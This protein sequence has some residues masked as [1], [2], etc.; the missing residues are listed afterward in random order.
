[1]STAVRPARCLFARA[2]AVARSATTPTAA[3]SA[4]STTFLRRQFHASPAHS[5][6]RKPHYPSIKVEDMKRLQEVAG[7]EFPTF[8]EKDKEVLAAKY[9]PEQLAA[10][11]AGEQA[12]DPRDLLVQG[13]KSPNN[14]RDW[15]P[16]ALKYQIDDLRRLQ[17]VLDKPQKAELDPYAD[18]SIRPR[19]EDEM[20]ELLAMFYVQEA[21][22]VEALGIQPGT[23]AE[24]EEEEKS[25]VRY[26]QFLDN[27]RTFMHAN[28]EEGY[29]AL[30]DDSYTVLA[31]ELPKIDELAPRAGS[32]GGSGEGD[33]EA[34]M[35]RLTKQTGMSKG[36]IRRLRLKTLVV[37]RVV[38]Q[39]RLGKVSSMY[40]LTIAGDGNGMLGIGEG[41]STEPEDGRRQSVMNAIRNMK[42]VV[43]YEG[44]TIYGEVEGKVGAVELKLSARPP[45]FGLR[46]QHLIFEM[47]R[48]A[49]I[50]DLAA[51]VT[52]SRN[53][54]NTIKATWEALLGQKLPEDIARARGRKLV[55]V[56]K[57]Y[58]GGN[59][60]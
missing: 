52:R 8:S 44:R 15:D 29:R 9:T 60:H 38:N 17:P 53:K 40:Y 42:P 5:K 33:E 31:P 48:A 36:E 14:N 59:V 3:A 45:G 56:R 16:M 2:S 4:D 28:S 27:P 26:L 49:G 13:W 41:K 55:D 11:E 10:I 25:R 51:R 23:R 58:Y 30:E 22:R 54:M 46:C 6:R 50:H 20:S 18:Y 1:M 57:V 12:L 47:A 24:K 37:R 39:T 43:R 19:T 21:E 32:G 34:N 7:S 35:A